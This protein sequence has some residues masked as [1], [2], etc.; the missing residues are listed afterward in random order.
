MD[1]AGLDEALMRALLREQIRTWRGPQPD[2]HW[3]AQRAYRKD[4]PMTGLNAD[5]ARRAIVEHTPWE[6]FF[7]SCH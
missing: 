6:E 3:P 2:R 1:G 4:N 5:H 7:V